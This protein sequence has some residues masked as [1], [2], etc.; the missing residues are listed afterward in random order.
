MH[1]LLRED[2]RHR[3]CTR[4]VSLT[5]DA[6]ARWGRFT[7][8]AMLSHII[9][10]MRVMLGD[11]PMPDER[12][13]WVVRHAPLKHLLI[14]VLPFPKGLPTSRVLLQRR[15]ADS[16]TMTKEDWKKEIDE[17]RTLVTRLQDSDPAAAWPTHAAFGAMSG[18]EWGVLQYRHIDHHLRQFGV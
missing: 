11:I 4:V 12:T 18:R 9:Q 8:P 14:Y 1:S 6:T 3:L 13:P 5:P 7:A 2:S 15:S 16:A 10:S 17:F